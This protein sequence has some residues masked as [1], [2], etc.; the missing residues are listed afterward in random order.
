MADPRTRRAKRF[1]MKIF[2]RDVTIYKAFLEYYDRAVEQG[3]ADPEALAMIW[4]RED[5]EETEDG[6]RKK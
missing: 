1:Y 6:W 5:Y 3:S 2:D 4:F